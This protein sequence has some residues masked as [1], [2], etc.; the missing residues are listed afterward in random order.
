[1]R[2]NFQGGILV[3]EQGV[4][5]GGMEWLLVARLDQGPGL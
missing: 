1:M 3:F 5:M 4:C 2:E